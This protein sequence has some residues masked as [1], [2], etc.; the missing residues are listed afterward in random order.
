MKLFKPQIN[1]FTKLEK[2]LKCENKFEYI[3]RI[4]NCAPLYLVVV[5]MKK[6]KID[7]ATNRLFHKFGKTWSKLSVQKL[8]ILT[9]K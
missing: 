3:N 5:W 9:A 1:Y 2:I 4:I 8:N 6:F 7:D